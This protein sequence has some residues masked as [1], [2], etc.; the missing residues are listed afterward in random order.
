MSSKV[1]WATNNLDVIC[2][3]VGAVVS[4]ILGIVFL[5]KS[6]YVFVVMMALSLMA[7]VSYMV[8][9]NRGK[10]FRKLD[11][12]VEDKHLPVVLDVLFGC[13]ILACMLAYWMRP[14]PME[15]PVA[16]YVMITMAV[17][18]VAVKILVSNEGWRNKLSTLTEIII[19]G[20]MLRLSVLGL[21]PNIVGQ[22]PWV[23]Y[24]YATKL[25]GTWDMIGTNA[26]WFV[27]HTIGALGMS[28]GLSY[29]EVT[30]LIFV[31]IQVVGDAVLIYLI[32]KELFSERIG[33]LASL[34]VMTAGWHIFFGY[35]V[36]PSTLATTFVLVAVFLLIRAHKNKNWWYFISALCFVTVAT[37]THPIPVLWLCA[38]LGIFVFG[39]LVYRYLY[40]QDVG[41]IKKVIGSSVLVVA[42]PVVSW[43]FVTGGYA[44]VL[45]GIRAVGFMYYINGLSVSN[46]VE[47]VAHAVVPPVI[48]TQPVVVSNVPLMQNMLG[49][50]HTPEYLLNI[51]GVLV[52]FAVA[53]VGVLY[54]VSKRRGNLYSFVLG[55]FGVCTTAIAIFPDMV[56]KGVFFSDRWCYL[57]QIIMA[58]PLAISLILIVRAIPKS[59]YKM[60]VMGVIVFIIC[61]LSIGGKP[62]NSDSDFMSKNQIVRL[63]FN[64]EELDAAKWAWENSSG[65]LI[66]LDSYYACVMASPNL[67]ARRE[68]EYVK[69]LTPY[70]SKGDFS[71]CDC[72]LVLI[73]KEIVDN[74]FGWGD[75]KIYR[76]FYDPNDVLIKQGWNK[77]FDNGEV[78]GYER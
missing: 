5:F 53:L 78:C 2:S 27:L 48:P 29:L 50:A 32:G 54:M 34:L 26:G 66:C 60:V 73:R 37:Y 65:E 20:F 38:L 49:G 58:I 15:R 51:M 52:F 23:H 64:Q 13:L 61:F 68:G 18:V 41:S 44:S 6:E 31:P 33:L 24:L 12:V 67:V 19:I 17:S 56:V 40:K 75:G 7:F 45:A 22:D 30:M 36:I 47:S 9:W 35:V 42:I 77:V 25:M 28:M 21:Y 8:L 59:I 55:V 74:P 69:P 71:K 63:G 11:G 62:A 46:P 14:M 57:G 10:L 70:L 39:M 16:F 72:K 3:I 4:L 43:L 1:L 76:L